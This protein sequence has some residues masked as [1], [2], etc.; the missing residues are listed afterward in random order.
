M[1]AVVEELFGIFLG[2]YRCLRPGWA[3]CFLGKNSKQERTAALAGF[4]VLH[5]GI[6]IE[7]GIVAFANFPWGQSFFHE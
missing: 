1:Q 2:L 6:C 7:V 4:G 5:G 3:N